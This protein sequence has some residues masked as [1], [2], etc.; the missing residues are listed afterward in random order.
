MSPGP[1]AGSHSGD[2]VQSAVK[3]GKEPRVPHERQ[4]PA[5]EVATEDGT[6]IARVH[7]RVT[8]ACEW[9]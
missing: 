1:I 7:V 3:I 5:R 6:R 4:R 8:P 2:A 9:L